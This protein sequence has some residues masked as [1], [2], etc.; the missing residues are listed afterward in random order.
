[1]N[2]EITNIHYKNNELW[3]HLLNKNHERLQQLV[4][5]APLDLIIK[6]IKNE[7]L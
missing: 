3:A 7:K 1:M 4:L 5:I 6:F 2:Y